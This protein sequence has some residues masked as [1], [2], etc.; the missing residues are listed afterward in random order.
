MYKSARHDKITYKVHR[1]FKAQ[2]T[3][4]IPSMLW[5]VRP[6]LARPRNIVMEST[7][8]NR[9]YRSTDRPTIALSGAFA[10]PRKATISFVMSV[11]PH[12]TNGLPLDGFS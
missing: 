11:R 6:S 10:K 3:F 2:L 9:L 7:Q 8:K 12:E 1:T 4:M 5:S